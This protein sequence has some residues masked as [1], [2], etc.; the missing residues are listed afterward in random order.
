MN[1]SAAGPGSWQERITVNPE[2]SC[3]QADAS[4]NADKCVPNPRGACPRCAVGHLLQDYPE[5]ERAD[6]LASIAYA[7]N[8]VGQERVYPVEA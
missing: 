4:W 1:E 5:L 6:I 2:G 7:A 3:R 8:L